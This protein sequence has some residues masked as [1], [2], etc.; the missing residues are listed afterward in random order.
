MG[1]SAPP[2]SAG[3]KCTNC[4]LQITCTAFTLA[5]HLAFY[6]FQCVPG[7]NYSGGLPAGGNRFG[8]TL[9]FDAGKAMGKPDQLKRGTSFQSTGTYKL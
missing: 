6:N 8:W 3:L 5:P 1:D 4:M 9:D 7:G 2:S